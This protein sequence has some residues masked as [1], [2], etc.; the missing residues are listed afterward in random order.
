[1]SLWRW[2]HTPRLFSVGFAS[3]Y[4]CA[5]T[6]AW[7]APTG[8]GADG[9]GEGLPE[10]RLQAGRPGPRWGAVRCGAGRHVVHSARLVSACLVSGVADLNAA[11][12]GLLARAR[13]G[14]IAGVKA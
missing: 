6:A 8:R 10:E 5:L 14:R 13:P 11:G 2:G 7:T 3:F 9:C 12:T 4:R 1:M